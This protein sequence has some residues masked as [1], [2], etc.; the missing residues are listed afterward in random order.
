MHIV[1]SLYQTARLFCKLSLWRGIAVGRALRREDRICPGHQPG[2][3]R[4]RRIPSPGGRK[5]IL[6]VDEIL[7][8]FRGWDLDTVFTHG[9]AP[10][11]T[12]LRRSAAGQLRYQELPCVFNRG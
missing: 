4:L 9:L 11:A 2:V 5:I 7:R 1:P 10:V 12:F 8:P 3:E 6:E